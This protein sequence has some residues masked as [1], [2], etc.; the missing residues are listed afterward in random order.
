MRSGVPGLEVAGLPR[1]CGP[2]KNSGRTAWQSLPHFVSSRS[3]LFGMFS[4]RFCR[5]SIF[6]T[7]FFDTVDV[8]GTVGIGDGILLIIFLL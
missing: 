3:N 2:L 5:T 7:L 6:R 1:W 8:V 4:N